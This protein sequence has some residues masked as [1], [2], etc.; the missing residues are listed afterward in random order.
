[1]RKVVQFTDISEVIKSF[2]V[3]TMGGVAPDKE[4]EGFFYNDVQSEAPMFE[5]EEFPGCH[6][7]DVAAFVDPR[8]RY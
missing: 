4:K 7:T 8:T 5:S 1:M 2:S 6:E 3:Q